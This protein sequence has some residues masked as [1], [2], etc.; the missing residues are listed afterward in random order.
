MAAAAVAIGAATLV[1]VVMWRRG[2]IGKGGA[3]QEEEEVERVLN[4]N[5]EEV[6]QYIHDELRKREYK[7]CVPIVQ[8]TWAAL[9]PNRLEP[10]MASMYSLFRERDPDAAAVFSNRLNWE[11]QQHAFSMMM[12]TLTSIADSPEAMERMLSPL[13]S[14]LC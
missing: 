4:L 9:K 6:Q 2:R 8:R 10:T 1:V 3:N 11:E 7:Q 5:E 12:G 13:V 14:H